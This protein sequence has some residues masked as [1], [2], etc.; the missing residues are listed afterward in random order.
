MQGVG[1]ELVM[2]G[3]SF[4]EGVDRR[5]ADVAEDDA[6]RAHGKLRQRALGMAVRAF[7]GNL[8]HAACHR[9]ARLAP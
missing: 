5:S 3:E 1:G 4:A 7:L 2:P 9:A 6:D 8:G